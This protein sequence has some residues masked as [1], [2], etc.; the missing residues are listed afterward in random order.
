MATPTETTEAPKKQSE[1][2]FQAAARAMEIAFSD[3]AHRL[4][5]DVQASERKSRES[6]LNNGN[7][8]FCSESMAALRKASELAQ[9]TA[10]KMK[11]LAK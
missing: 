2:F 11:Q 3:Y 5:M 9:Q 4:R 8:L 7:Q 1:V 6:G 10:D